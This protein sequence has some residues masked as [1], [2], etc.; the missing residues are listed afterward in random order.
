LILG[1]Q[2]VAKVAINAFEGDNNGV[3][4]TGMNLNVDDGGVGINYAVVTGTGLP[5]AALLLFNQASTQSS[6]SLA[7]GDPTTYTGTSTTQATVPCSYSNCVRDVG[8]A[9]SKHHHPTRRLY[10]EAV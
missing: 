5:A 7:A 3:L 4:C 9:D 10:R 2:L 8:P 1:N 6:F